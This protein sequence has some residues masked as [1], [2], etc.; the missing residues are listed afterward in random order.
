MDQSPRHTK[1]DRFAAAF[2]KQFADQSRRVIPYF[3]AGFPDTETVAELIRRADRAG[4]T[5][6]EIG[7]PYSDS[8]ADGPVIQSSFYH[9]L[10][11]GFRVQHA[12]DM[13]SRLRGAVSCPLIAM[14]SYSIVHR[15]GLKTFMHDAAMAGFDGVIVPDV[16]EEEGSIVRQAVVYSGSACVGMIGPRTSKERR[17]TI[18]KNSS[19]FIYVIA[20]AGTTGERSTLSGELKSQ[21][22]ELRSFTELPLCVGFGVANAQQVREVCQ[23]ADAAI[24]GSAIIKRVTSSLERNEPKETLINSVS[25]FVTELIGAGSS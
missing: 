10:D 8:I 11:R 16:P 4:A 25:S 18:A 22:E 19:G 1:T 17:K 2:G 12:L 24:V 23:F 20:A 6:V 7:F 15:I 5:A 21:I 9:A 3:T 14:L 13:V